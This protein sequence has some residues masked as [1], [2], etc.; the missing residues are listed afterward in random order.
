VDPLTITANTAHTD[1]SWTYVKFAASPA[2]QQHV[3]E[4]GRMTNTPASI[5]QQWAPIVQK[6]YHF[7]HAREFAFA[8]GASIVAT[9]NVDVNQLESKGGLWAARDAVILGKETAKEALAT[10][11]TKCQTLLDRWWQSHPNG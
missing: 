5:V 11:Q 8:Q 7:Q 2:G 3:A 1:A 10:A 9:G 4:G 6:L